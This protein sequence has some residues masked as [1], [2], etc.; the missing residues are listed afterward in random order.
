MSL[1]ATMTMALFIQL[2]TSLLLITTTAT[3][4][5]RGFT[6]DLIQRRS[7]SFSSRHSNTNELDGGSPYAD[8][9]FDTNAYLIK[10]QM[11]TPPVEIEAVLE[12]GSELI[13]TQ[14]M[15]C[16]NCYNQ[17]GPIFDPSKSSTY[18]EKRCGKHGHACPYEM[19][20]GGGGY[21]QGNYAKETVTL[22]STSGQPFVMNETTIGCAHN[23]SGFHTTASGIVGLDWGPSSLISQMGENFLGLFSYCFSGKGTS[24]INF[25]GNAIVA[26]DG[27]VATNMFSNKEQPQY[28]YLNLDA[29]SV[30]ENRVETLG[31]SFHSLEGNIVI[32]SGTTYTYL[33]NTYCNLVKDSVDKALLNVERA[34]FSGGML[35]YK[36]DDIEVFPVMTMHFSGG[37]DLK[38][39]KYNM[40][41]GNGGVYCLAI[42]CNDPTQQAI[43]GN[44]AQNNWLVGYDTSSQLVSFKSTDCSALWS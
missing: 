43:F 6:I 35:C 10:L 24:K 42:V 29:I 13:W 19:N 3:S 2:I 21:S 32:D 5:P 15:P 14:C 36:T 40:F 17:Q 20:Y 4:S 26:G 41:M 23:S 25:G 28:Y 12:T 31:T 27:T 1:V 34:P 38:M 8:T 9:V 7:K 30:G 44:R 33:P 11:G 37:A 22:L 39:D 16:L 18:K